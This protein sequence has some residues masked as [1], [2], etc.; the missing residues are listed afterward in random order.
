M[1][2]N[3][4]Y[5][6]TTSVLLT[7]NDNH[8]D[9]ESESYYSNEEE[10]SE[11]KI[12]HRK[13]Y[14]KNDLR[15]EIL[16]HEFDKNKIFTSS[17][18]LTEQEKIYK[19]RVDISDE[20]KELKNDY[21]SV[22]KGKVAALKIYQNITPKKEEYVGLTKMKDKYED[23]FEQEEINRKK[24]I[25]V[26]LQELDDAKS[27]IEEELGAN[28]TRSDLLKKLKFNDSLPKR[29]RESEYLSDDESTTSKKSRFSTNDYI[30]NLPKDY[31]P[32]E[33]VG[34]D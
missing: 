27:Y 31:D 7:D 25:K 28:K 1:T 17:D 21:Y 33:D 20:K 19:E 5:Y 23:F 32:F 2:N 9:T 6:S 29:K 34:S 15:K 16:K 3:K 24:E 26:I 11:K 8:S 14:F 10:S 22:I 18:L 12:E 13:T 4:K 30:D